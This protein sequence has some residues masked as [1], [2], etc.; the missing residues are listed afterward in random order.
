MS[1]SMDQVDQLMHSGISAQIFPG[2]VLKVVKASRQVFERSYGV[3]NLFSGRPMTRHMVFDLASLTKPLATVMAVMALIGRGRMEL[4][5]AC[6]DFCPQLAGT[7][8]AGITVRQLLNHSSGFLPWRPYFMA[9]A[10]LEAGHRKEALKH[11]LMDGPLIAPPGRRSAY[12]DLGYMML[13]WVVEQV[14]GIGLDRFV[15]EAV[16]RPLGIEGLCFNP[17]ESMAPDPSAYAATQLCPWRSRLLVGSVDDE[18]A[19]VLGGIGG[20]AGLFG[21][22]Q[23]VMKLLQ[24]LLA[25]DQDNDGGGCLEPS[26]V[27]KFFSSGEKERWALGFDTPSRHG[28]SAGKYF[29][30]DSVGHLGFTGTSF[31]VHRQKRIIV[32]LL[33]NRVHPWRFNAGI[34][35]FRPRLHDAIMEAL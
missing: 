17:L 19:S 34:R 5:Q 18:N 8:K 35:H 2:A 12:S 28:S 9:L 23:A 25:A 6:V 11:F 32:V 16:Y 27:K 21:T 33:T 7:D 24:A 30:V 29:S 13:Q 26:L 20:H 22:V 1:T 10:P 4:D 15:D 14:S 31:W 3:A